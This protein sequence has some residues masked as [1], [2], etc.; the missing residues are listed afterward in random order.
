M[1][2]A[3]ITLCVFSINKQIYT[4]KNILYLKTPDYHWL[5]ISDQLK[6]NYDWNCLGWIGN[7]KK[8]K[9]IDNIDLFFDQNIFF[10][11]KV[12]SYYRGKKLNTNSEELYEI[13]KKIKYHYP[14]IIELIDRWIDNSKFKNNKLKI[15]YINKLVNDI[16]IFLKFYKID[17]IISPT[18]PHRIYDYVFYL[19]FNFQKKPF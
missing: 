10:L 9:Y 11:N 17:L 8:N 6:K 13:K 16:F 19:I 14:I 7:P 4:L 18:I 5:K 1:R 15:K 3:Y 12:D 2:E